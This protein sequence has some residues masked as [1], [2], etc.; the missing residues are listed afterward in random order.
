ML[1]FSASIWTAS[2]TGFAI[3][4]PKRVT[5]SATEFLSTKRLN[6]VIYLSTLTSNCPPK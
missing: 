5:A 1:A 2:K 6:L 4:S 3:T